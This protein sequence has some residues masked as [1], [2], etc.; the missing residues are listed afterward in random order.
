MRVSRAET[1]PIPVDVAV[2]RVT[3][4][5]CKGEAPAGQPTRGRFSAFDDRHYCVNADWG[6]EPDVRGWLLISTLGAPDT[7]PTQQLDC[8]PKCAGIHLPKPGGA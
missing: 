4:D 2:T 6:V 7:I 1:R 5:F 3:C 8:C